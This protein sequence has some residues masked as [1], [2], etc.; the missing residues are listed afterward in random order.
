MRQ[1]V[2]TH[3]TLK[4]ESKQVAVGIVWGW[5][6][7]AEPCIVFPLG[8]RKSAS[9][10]QQQVAHYYVLS[11]DD[12]GNTSNL[13]RKCLLRETCY[14]S[15]IRKQVVSDLNMPW[16]RLLKDTKPPATGSQGVELVSIKAMCE[17]IVTWKLPMMDA[18]N[19]QYIY[20]YY[21][22]KGKWEHIYM[23]AQIF[24]NKTLAY[25]HIHMNRARWLI[26]NIY[27]LQQ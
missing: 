3:T 24:L 21:K 19:I 23:A 8:C 16:K 2:D 6:T 7:P 13:D 14:D 27:Y 11:G 26:F 9:C 20:L 15:L 22:K 10:Q 4:K 25:V 17:S 12:D 1:W 18:V 5:V